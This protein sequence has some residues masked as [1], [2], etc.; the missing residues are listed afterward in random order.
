VGSDRLD[1]VKGETTPRP[2]RRSS[3]ARLSRPGRACALGDRAREDGCGCALDGDPFS[4]FTGAAPGGPAIGACPPYVRTASA[5]DP[6]RGHG[7]KRM[8]RRSR[9]TWRGRFD[10]THRCDHRC[11]GRPAGCDGVVP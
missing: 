10:G 3:A 7:L 5:V 2:D 6:A 1:Q 4:G 11:H 8:R 9:V